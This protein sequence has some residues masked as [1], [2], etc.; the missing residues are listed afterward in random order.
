MRVSHTALEELFSQA[1]ILFAVLRAPDYVFERVNDA[2]LQLVGNREV[3]GKPL[4]QAIPELAGQ[5]FV[6][7]LD[8]VVRTGTPFTARGMRATVQKVANAAPE[9]VWVDFVYQPLRGEGNTV[10]GVIVV[11]SDVTQ[12][13]VA[14]REAESKA[15][16]L[17]ASEEQFRTAVNSIP[18]LAWM[19]NSDGW[20]FWY[21][22]RW[23]EYTGTSPEQMEGWGWQAVHD[24]AILPDVMERWAASIATGDPFEMEFP[25]RSASGEYRWFLTRVS[26]LFDAN[27]RITRWF[28]TNTDVHAQREAAAAAIAANEAK[29]SFLA[30][31]SHETRQPINATLGFVDVLELGM[32]GPL[33]AEQ[34]N[35]LARI[36]LNQEQLRALVNDVLTFARLEVG[37]VRL[38]N[39]VL[40][41]SELLRDMPSLVEPQVAARGLTM[42]VEPCDAAV[43]ARGDRNRV[44]QICTNLVTNSIRATEKGGVIT[45]RCAAQD[46]WVHIE[47]QDNGCGIP[48]DKLEDIFAP[49]VQL[50]RGLNRPRDGAGLGLAIS[51]DL[52]RAMGG[53]LRVRSVLGSGATFTLSLPKANQ[54]ESVARGT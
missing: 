51:R 12:Q 31:M 21:N 48:E 13:F 30:S 29:S 2:Y 28:G 45:V 14:L 46:S 35:A 27:G 10:E 9:E 3:L 36:R 40:T 15:R 39:D 53:D 18:A 8:D 50:D 52:A 54:D 6:E 17:A 42:R 5:G 32:Y 22:A 33:N 41:C 4:L 7:L 49:F 1:P 23:Y 11:G 16:A 26:P 47:I 34:K 44:L 38:D 43:A 20:I 25:L 19:A 37:T 24:P